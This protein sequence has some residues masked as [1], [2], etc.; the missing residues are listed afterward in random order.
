VNGAMYLTKVASLRRD[1]SFLNNQTLA[2]LMPPE[3]SVD[4]DT[5]FDFKIASYLK[6][7]GTEGVD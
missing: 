5:A 2:Y 7:S 6:T 1:Q 4:I 3:R